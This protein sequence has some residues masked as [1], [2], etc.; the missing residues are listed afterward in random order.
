[1]PISVRSWT[2]VAFSLYYML[3]ATCGSMQTSP[4]G[5]KQS[6]ESC[7]DG[8]NSLALKLAIAL[9]FPESTHQR[10]P[11]CTGLRAER[12]SKTPVHNTVAGFSNLP[13]IENALFSCAVIISWS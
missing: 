7:F 12:R 10:D 9:V 6:P 2:G 11:K 8:A 3:V 4:I 5:D 1:M 13:R